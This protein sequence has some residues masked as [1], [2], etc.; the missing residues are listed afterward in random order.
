[1]ADHINR[2][3]DYLKH[4]M[5]IWA[6]PTT[7]KNGFMYHTSYMNYKSFEIG[8]QFSIGTFLVKPFPVVHTNTD[9]SPCENSGFLIYS[10]VTKEKMLWITD[11]SY[12]ESRFPPV[13]YIGI[14]C[15]YI[16]AEDYSD[17]I[18]N[19]DTFVEKRRFT[20]HLS[21]KRCK[22][23]LVAQDLS[24]VKEIRLIHLSKSIIKDAGTQM[25]KSMKEYFPEKKFIV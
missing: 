19:V 3:A 10:T 22:Q 16:D 2:A 13:D 18:E 15:N 9:G 12:I 21:L 4:G 25:L 20:S 5:R 24:K 11:A 14:E 1:M 17:I 6:T 7:W 23:F 8:K